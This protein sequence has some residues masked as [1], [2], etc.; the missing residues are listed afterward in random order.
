MHNT[1]AVKVCAKL[2]SS[3]SLDF[4]NLLIQSRDHK[5][6]FTVEF[7]EFLLEHVE[8]AVETRHEPMRAL[9]VVCTQHSA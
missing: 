4:M 2:L 8:L 1:L 7:D 5:N 9:E 3:K 6:M